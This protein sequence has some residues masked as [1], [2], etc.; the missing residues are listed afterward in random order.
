MPE[1]CLSPGKDHLAR[2]HEPVPPDPASA[3]QDVLVMAIEGAG[4]AGRP[5][6]CPPTLLS[7]GHCVAGGSVVLH[8]HAARHLPPPA[9]RLQLWPLSLPRSE[10]TGCLAPAGLQ[11]RPWHLVS[12]LG[13]L[14]L[15]GFQPLA[16]LPAPRFGGVSDGHWAP[17]GPRWAGRGERRLAL[18]PCA[19]DPAGGRAGRSRR[20]SGTSNSQ[21][22][23]GSPPR[24]VLPH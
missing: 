15:G 23:P 11:Q 5:E 12:R 14:G 20:A 19:Q 6:S 1:R 7:C 8:L 4:I 3:L 10:Q 9:L 24:P 16:G 18:S 17:G 21:M 2:H 13:C 22:P